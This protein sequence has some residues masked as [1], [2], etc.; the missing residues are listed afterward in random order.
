VLPQGVESYGVTRRITLRVQPPGGDFAGVT[1]GS[2]ILSGIYEETMTLRG[3]GTAAREY[4]V[5]GGFALHRVSEIP[6]LTE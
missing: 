3:R 4:Q 1:A 6:V 2:G 5:R